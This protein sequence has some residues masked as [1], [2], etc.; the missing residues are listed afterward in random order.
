MTETH[1]P[2]GWFSSDQPDRLT[3]CGET[4][5]V[6]RKKALLRILALREA[7]RAKLRPTDADVEAMS[8]HFRR[9]HGLLDG[10]E[11]TRWLDAQALSREGFARAMHDFTVVTLV[12]N[13][14]AREID[15]L[16]A[17]HIAVSTARCRQTR[18]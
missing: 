5:A 13:L 16:V 18:G 12:E 2:G 10:G 11:L 4:M 8:Q 3:A 7:E 17:D 1:E 14:Y 15:A 9:H 6:V